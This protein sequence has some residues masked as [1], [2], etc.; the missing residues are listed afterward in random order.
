VG[1]DGRSEKG[2]EGLLLFGREAFQERW[3]VVEAATERIKSL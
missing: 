1:A 2:S 3:E